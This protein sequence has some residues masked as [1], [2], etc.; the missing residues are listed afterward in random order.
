[1]QRQANPGTQTRIR[2][3]ALLALGLALMGLIQLSAPALAQGL[4][5]G[6]DADPAGNDATTLGPI[7]PCISVRTGDTFTIDIFIQDVKDLLAWELYVGYD[8]AIVEISKR[9]VRLFQAANSGSAVFD[10]SETLPDSDGLY[11]LAAADTSDPP[12]PDSGSGVLARLTL[13]AVAAGISPVELARRDLDDDGR[14]DLGPFLRDV[15]G[16]I[17]GD[18]NGDSFAD[19]ATASAEIAVDRACAEPGAGEEPESEG[20]ISPLAVVIPLLSVGAIAAAG[21]AIVLLRRRRTA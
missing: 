8:P 11:R 13:K 3:I 5:L 12:M 15:Q 6:I 4:E 20:G 9:D 17:I 7:N 16:K 1:M 14:F 18:S 10:V 2:F 19:V 21:A